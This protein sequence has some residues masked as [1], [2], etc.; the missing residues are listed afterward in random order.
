MPVC[1]KQLRML[2][3]FA[4]TKCLAV[5]RSV[6]AARNKLRFDNTAKLFGPKLKYQVFFFFIQAKFLKGQHLVAFIQPAQ[7]YPV[8]KRLIEFKLE[9]ARCGVAAGVKRP[10]A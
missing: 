1:R 6:D 5:K 4:E 9:K 2:Q 8:L 7:H 3:F 10:R